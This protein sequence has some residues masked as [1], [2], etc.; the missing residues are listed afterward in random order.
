LRLRD[1]VCCEVDVGLEGD[2]VVD[3]WSYLLMMELKMTKELKCCSMKFVS[4][5]VRGKKG[6]QKKQV[7]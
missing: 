2:V 1:E 5:C 3:D 7:V 6:E 4:G